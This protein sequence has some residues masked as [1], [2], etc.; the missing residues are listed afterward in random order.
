MVIIILI[1]NIFLPGIGTMIISCLGEKHSYSFIW[2]GILQ[3]MLAPL[4][5]GWIWSIFTGYQLLKSSNENYMDRSY[6]I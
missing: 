2:I 6:V 5:C 1:I 3:F 4:L